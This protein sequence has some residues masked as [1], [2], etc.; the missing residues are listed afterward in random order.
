MKISAVEIKNLKGYEDSG[1]I[2]FSPSIN[3]LLGSNNSGKSTIVRSCFLVQPSGGQQQ[4]ILTYLSKNKRKGTNS[5]SVK[6]EFDQADTYYLSV[7]DPSNWASPTV[8]FL[9]NPGFQI[10]FRPRND[11][12]NNHGFSLLSS[13]E[14]KNFIYPYFSKRKATGFTENFNLNH[15]VEVKENLQD[16]YAKVN[17]I[18]NS[19]YP[20]NSDYRKACKEIIGLNISCS[21]SPNGQQAGI[22]VSNSDH[23][24]LDEMGEGTT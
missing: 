8:E 12:N 4:S 9:L 21:L 17:R 15:A 1:R 6:I 16:L 13:H 22:I 3:L 2:E 24:P 23:I 7:G 5:T 10:L 19:D 14:P 20:A 11:K 18:S